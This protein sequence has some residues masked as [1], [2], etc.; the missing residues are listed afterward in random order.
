MPAA[1]PRAPCSRCRHLPY[2]VHH[3]LART[4]PSRVEDHLD[5]SCPL[6]QVGAVTRSSRLRH[7]TTYFNK[8]PR[9]K[10][11]KKTKNMEH[12]PTCHSLLLCN[13]KMSYA[14]SSSHLRRA[15]ICSLSSTSKR[16][17]K[18]NGMLVKS[19]RLLLRF[20]TRRS[21]QHRASGIHHYSNAA[22][23]AAAVQ[24]CFRHFNDIPSTECRQ[25]GAVVTSGAQPTS[26]YLRCQAGCP[27][28]PA[29]SDQLVK[30]AGTRAPT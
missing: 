5:V 18:A 9:K 26:A 1:T 14:F 7:N 4:R 19:A 27:C 2:Y 24:V 28:R 30:P 3:N 10:K 12:Q 13:L 16:N 17:A 20:A 21:L 15:P 11:E 6:P 25:G 8:A 23:G 29:T 22:R